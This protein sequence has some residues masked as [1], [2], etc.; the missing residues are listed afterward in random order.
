MYFSVFLFSVLRV[1]FTLIIR[2]ST[3]VVLYRYVYR[4][5]KVNEG[6]VVILTGKSEGNQIFSHTVYI[7]FHS[8][9]FRNH[10]ALS[11]FNSMPFSVAIPEIPAPTTVRT[12]TVPSATAI[13]KNKGKPK[14]K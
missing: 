13:T 9:L 3:I 12:T 11:L 7:P 10:S 8:F 4:D 1:H 14:C 6:N 5:L 2:Q